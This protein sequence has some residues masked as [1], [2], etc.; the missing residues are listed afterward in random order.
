MRYEE[1]NRLNKKSNLKH[2]LLYFKNGFSELFNKPFKNIFVLCY[3]VLTV[4]V[5]NKKNFFYS[6]IENLYFVDFIKILLNI[7]IFIFMILLFIYVMQGIGKPFGSSKIHDNLL[8]I[9]LTNNANEHP[10]LLSNNKNRNNIISMEFLNQGIPLTEFEKK[11]SEI[12]ATLNVH[13]P[14]ME[15]GKNNN[16][17]VLHT[18]SANYSLAKII[19]WQED[20]IN[21]EDFILVLGESLLGKVTVDLTKIPHLLLGGSSGSGKSMLL[22]LLLHQC[23]KKEASIYIADFKGG[24]DFHATDYNNCKMIFEENDLNN[25]LS[26]LVDDLEKRKTLFR[27]SGVENINKYNQSGHD[28]Q[29]IIFACD[30]IA[31][32]LDKTGLSKE[33]KE[34]VLQ[35]ESKLSII[36]RQGRAFGIH[37]I[38]ATQRPD[39]NIL[40][41]QIKNNIS[42]KVCG[43]AD[44]VLSSIIL[45]NTNASKLIPSD[46]QGLFL[47]QDNVLF[48][49]Y[50]FE[51][52]SI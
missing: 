5:W 14:K 32:V 49:A 9:G 18:L 7:I 41:G 27:E 29:R 19:P 20:F 48:Q 17:I 3:I 39:A 2:E 11:Q 34:I 46:S 33:K 10:I 36:A 13:I 47:N 15:Y 35:I 50:L 21:N 42:Y 38:L 22:K 23:R 25:T 44:N 28:M 1:Q 8:K 31:E 51:E 6:F 45:D 4:I 30:E 26:I 40:T 43:R 16:F 24:V 37:L 12:E 52:D